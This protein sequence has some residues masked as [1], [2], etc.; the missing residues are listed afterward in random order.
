ML[1]SEPEKQELVEKKE[2]MK[3]AETKE[4]TG[5]GKEGIKIRKSQSEKR[6]G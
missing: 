1:D 5:K 4:V 3:K 2:E 6:I